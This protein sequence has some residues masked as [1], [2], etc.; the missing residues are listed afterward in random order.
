MA[1][2]PSCGVL[3]PLVWGRAGV[4][5]RLAAWAGENCGHLLPEDPLDSG[6]GLL[7]SNILIVTEVAVAASTSAEFQSALESLRR[8]GD[9]LM[10]QLLRSPDF[11]R[12]LQTEVAE[13]LAAYAMAASDQD[14]AQA[15][16]LAL[17]VA[18]ALAT[19]RCAHP[20]CVTIV[21]AREAAA[22]RGK[23]CSGCRLV[24][25]CGPRCQKADWLA[26]RAA[27]RVVASRRPAAAPAPTG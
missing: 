14:P 6:L 20:C 1:T 8:P 4:L 21:G 3:V 24:R 27:C 7:L 9:E 12:R 19:R 15:A 2:S 13:P 10:T 5:T 11:W 18:E 17:E 26:H 23:L 25:Y 16:A 22:P